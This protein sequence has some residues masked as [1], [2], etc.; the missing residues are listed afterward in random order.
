MLLE[1]SGQVLLL[2]YRYC[3][4]FQGSKQKPH[5]SI[6][7]EVIRLLPHAPD[8]IRTCDL[9]LR[10]PT[11]Y[12]TELRALD[13][14]GR[15]PLQSGNRGDTR[16]KPSSVPAKPGRTISLGSASLRTSCSLPGTQMGRAAPRPC[17]ALLQVGFSVRPPLPKARCALTAP[18]HPCLC[19]LTEAIGG[20]LSVALSIGFRRPGVTRHPAL[21][22]SDFPPMD[23]VT[24]PTSD[25]HSRV[26]RQPFLSKEPVQSWPGSLSNISPGVH[27][28]PI[29]ANVSRRKPEQFTG[30]CVVRSSA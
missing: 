17:L 10:R 6:H 14:P 23:T 7:T 5:D 27:T 20:L 11:L 26:P 28:Q 18:F 16:N 24:R 2:F 8:R 13:D 29:R 15:F 12:P 25:P 9:R 21:W 4:G 1:A 30:S 3:F 22:S 19:S